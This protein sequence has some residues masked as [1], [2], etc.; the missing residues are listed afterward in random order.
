MLTS[1]FIIKYKEAGE[2]YN[3][4][5]NNIASCLCEK[6]KAKTAGGKRWCKYVSTNK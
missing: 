2:Y 6:S 1:R 3:I 4:R 5:P